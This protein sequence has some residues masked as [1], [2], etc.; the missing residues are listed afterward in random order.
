MSLKLLFPT[1]R[2]RRDFVV[3]ALERVT[4]GA[5]VPRALNLGTGEGDFDRAIKAFCEDLD[6]CDLNAEDVAY[7]RAANAG[8]PRIRYAV[9]D[10]TALSYPDAAFDFVTCI[11]VIEHVDDP[12]R[13]LSE[14]VRVLKPGGALVLSGPHEHFPFTYD[15]VNFVLRKLSG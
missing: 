15:P 7:A 3:G 13:L 1:F 5:R 12:K 2:A 10:G 14:I 11:D 9:E 6:A 8:E 4:G